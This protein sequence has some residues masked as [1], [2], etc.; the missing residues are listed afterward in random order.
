LINAQLTNNSGSECALMAE[1]GKPTDALDTFIE[2]KEVV[3]SSKEK[4]S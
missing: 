4:G 3:T 1:R 2:F